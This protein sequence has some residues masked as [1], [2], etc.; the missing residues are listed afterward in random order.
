MEVEIDPPSSVLPSIV[1]TSSLIIILGEDDKK[2]K[3]E[4]LPPEEEW[5][6]VRFPP[7]KRRPNLL[8]DKILTGIKMVLQKDRRSNTAKMETK[9]DSPVNDI[10]GMMNQ[11]APMLENW[12]RE[13]LKA[14]G[15]QGNPKQEGARK[16]KTRQEKKEAVPKAT[17]KNKK[18]TPDNKSASVD[19]TRRSQTQTSGVQW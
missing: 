9:K 2:R 18:T 11:L 6:A 14:L 13:S 7:L 15:V 10:Q 4:I 5:P 16:G 8:E 3:R 17:P 19:T 1:D 12:L